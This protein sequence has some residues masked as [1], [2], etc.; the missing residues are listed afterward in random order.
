MR[1]R[2]VASRYSASVFALGLAASI[3]PRS[4]LNSSSVMSLVQ[5]TTFL[6]GVALVSSGGTEHF[7]ASSVASMFVVVCRS[8]CECR[9]TSSLSLVNVTSHSTMPAPIRA[10]ASYDSFVCSGNCRAAP[11]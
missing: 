3:L 8:H 4:V 10:A 9:H 5:H 7:S 2:G 1:N 11:R 6:K